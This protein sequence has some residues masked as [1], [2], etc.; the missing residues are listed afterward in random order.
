MKKALALAFIALWVME[1]HCQIIINELMQSNI[2]CIMDDQNEFPDSWV[3]L[4]NAGSTAVNLQAYSIGTKSNGSDSYD[5][6]NQMI[7]PHGFAL[8]YCDKDDH[9][10]HTPWRLDSGKGCCVYLFH[11]GAI[12][13]KVENL[14][15]QPAPNIAYGRETNGSDIW[16]YMLNPTPGSSNSGGVSNNILGEPIFSEAGRVLTSSQT[17]TIGFSLPEGTPEDA[18]I[19]YTLN[20]SEPTSSSPLYSAPFTISSSRTIRAKLF[21]NGWLSPRSTTQSYLFL[22]REMTLPV[23]SIA[24]D[25]KYLNDNK[26]GIYVSGTY[27]SGK[28]NY[29]FNW[30]RPINIEYFEEAGSPSQL[31]Q[32]CETR[33][34]GGATRS[35]PLKSLAIYANKRFG[36]KRFEY[37]FF[38]DQ[39]PGVTDFK[40]LVLRNAG[41]DFDYLYMRD[42]IIQRSMA[43]HVDLDW[44]AWRP[45]IIFINGVYK[46]IQNIRERSNEDNIYTHYDGLEDIDMI[47]KWWE[48]KEGDWENWNAFKD[49]YAEH[50]HTLEEYAQWID[51][52]E[53]I[54]LM[55][56]NLY[57]N[58]QDFPGNNIVM[59]R[60]RTSGGRWRFIAKDTDFGLGLYGSSSSYNSIEWLYNPNYD[61]NRAWANQYEYTRL[62]RRMMEDPDFQREFLDR[63]AIYMGDFLNEQGVR[64][65]WDPMYDMI[66][67]EYPY[68]R[69]L[70][71]EWPNYNSELTQARNWLSSRTNYFYTQLANYYEIGTPMKLKVN[72]TLSD[73][74][75]AS[76]GVLF[77]GVRLSKSQFDGKFYAN[78][79]ITLSGEAGSDKQV[80]GWHVVEVST[81]GQVTT[82]DVSG[83]TYTFMMPTCSSLTITALLSEVDGIEEMVHRDWRWTLSGDALTVEGVEKGVRVSVYDTRGMLLMSQESQGDALTLPL[84]QTGLLVLKVGEEAVKVRK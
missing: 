80:T 7:P 73:A 77:N 8:V 5:L 69:K 4:Y 38:P 16:G 15:K 68:H 47:E 25:S 30:R 67:T 57:F 45:A 2:D 65:V 70:I 71:N 37:E 19:R 39:R 10:M 21:C 44:Q 84:R 78:R 27:Q 18:Q 33:I 62:F 82:Q 55:A 61:S 59:W 48:L 42:A 43:Q 83:S 60:P 13:D 41:N 58:N 32:L 28:N 34:Q 76:I 35:N 79:A 52:E 20:G 36:T 50:G 49:F 63:C 31:N 24:T 75:R 74:E 26:I 72:T 22:N 46:G 3:E 64:A 12:E 56:M 29:E 40:S 53:F 66:K 11:Q 6:P 23:I 51:W 1:G 54:N 17:I 9:D 14:K 81:N